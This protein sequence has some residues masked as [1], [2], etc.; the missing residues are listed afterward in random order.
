MTQAAV[1]LLGVWG[2][3]LI[4]AQ[5]ADLLSV[6]GTV[7]ELGSDG[8]ATVPVA[9]AEVSFIEFVL[10]D[11]SPTRSPVATAYTD[12]R[13]DYQ[14]HPQHT[15]DYYVEVKK[16]GY[17]HAPSGSY[18]ASMKLDQAHPTAKATFTLMR[19]GASITGRV[20]DEDGQPVPGL[21]I[22]VQ[23]AVALRVPG[24]IMGVDV[25]AVT[26]A[27]GTFTAADLSPGPHV[28][29]ISPHVRYQAKVEPYFSADDLNTVDQDLET[30]YWP[31]GTAQAI[32][33]VPVSPG[34]STT[35]GTI[36]IRKMSYY[37]VHVSVP[38]V[39]C[40]AGEKWT[41]SAVYSGEATFT[42]SNQITCTGDFLVSNLRPG[43]YS[44]RLIRDGPPRK[45]ALASV[46][47]SNKNS[48]VALS[49]EPEA[50]IHGRL[51]AL[52]GASLP[53]FNK[54]EILV[55]PEGP[56]ALQRAAPDA[57]GKFVLTNLAFPRHRISV[58]GLTP[59]YYAKEIR[60]NGARLPDG[61]VT[62]ATAANQVEIVID[63]KPGAIAGTVFDG[64]KPVT[65]A[66]VRLF[67]KVPSQLANPMRNIRTDKQGRFQ[68]NGL[69]PGEYQI[70]A[71]PSATGPQ[72]VGYAKAVAQL[73]ASAQSVKVERGGTV[74]V[75][76]PL[77]DP[78]Q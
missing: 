33:S 28:I 53:P 29:Q 46:V 78:S 76:L 11:G 70:L 21:K 55:V 49:F 63:D 59:S 4:Y 5:P 19:A 30:S 69:T 35:V 71:L 45:W 31:G 50:Q 52:E 51:V 39:E 65:E 17:R 16:G 54:I 9:G 61:T 66:M 74:T 34:A 48:E 6:S 32:A 43:T 12:A 36:K 47:V 62:L 8:A 24:V 72:S 3:G 42:K 26:A 44:F 60:L 1:L 7:F 56:S 57:E 10:V 77:T 14:F 64:H 18:G 38:R 27:D 20:V 67:P 37:R 73:A 75:T 23:V 2:T 13:G 68:I 15:G 25:T 41:F 40:E 58:Q 22:A